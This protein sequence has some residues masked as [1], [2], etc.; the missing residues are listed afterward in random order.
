[1]TE[2][3]KGASIKHLQAKMKKE[4]TKLSHHKAKSECFSKSFSRIDFDLLEEQP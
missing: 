2:K 3:G 1:M 4:L